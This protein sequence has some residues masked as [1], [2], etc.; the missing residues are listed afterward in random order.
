[1][2]AELHNHKNIQ[3]LTVQP[4]YIK[5]NVPCNAIIGGR[6]KNNLNNDDHLDCFSSEYVAKKIV[7]A[8]YENKNELLL[9][10]FLHRFAIWVRFF[11]PHLFFHFMYKRAD[12]TFRKEFN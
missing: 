8:I 1:M 12:K 10:V 7:E 4:G 3:V 9:T 6:F 11:M 5:T 2:R